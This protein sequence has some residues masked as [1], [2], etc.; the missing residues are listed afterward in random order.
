M[1]AILNFDLAVFEFVRETFWNPVMDTVM[2]VYTHLGEAGIIWI[3]L[4]IVLLISKKYRKAGIAVLASLLVMEII[5]NEVLKTFIARPRPFMQ[6]AD[7]TNADW[8]RS[9][10]VNL[11]D[12]WEEVKN[13]GDLSER[14]AEGYVWP[15]LVDYPSSWSFPSGH[16]S[17]AFAAVMG[18]SLGTKKAKFIVPGFI[19][20][21]L[22]GFTRIYVHVHYATDV[23]GGALV[24]II[25]G[26]I[27]YFIAVA[28]YKLIV[29]KF[30]KFAG[31]EA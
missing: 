24:G 13:I 30:P 1:E 5:N 3:L 20:A 10:P 19:A 15:A 27:G 7:W 29:K 25:Y 23:I 12:K 28:V 18:M 11:L 16:T 2:T 6:F 22:M 21:A 14:W 9:L 31:K 26:I 4:G 8:P 17:S